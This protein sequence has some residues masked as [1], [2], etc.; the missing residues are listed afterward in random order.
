MKRTAGKVKIHPPSF[1][2]CPGIVIVILT[3]RVKIT[4]MYKRTLAIKIEKGLLQN[5]G[6]AILGPRQVGK[7]TLALEIA[8]D[9]PSIYLDLEKQEDFAK[10][11]DPVAFLSS[12]FDKLVILDE[13]Q[14]YPDLFMSLRGL[15]DTARRAGKGK[16]RYIMLGSAS[17]DLLRQTSES[18][19][20]RIAY[21]ELNGLSPMEV[22]AIRPDALRTLWLRGGFPDSYEAE[23]DAQSDIWRKNFI[24]TYV[25]RDIPLLGPRIP[26]ATLMRF[27]TMLAHVQG[28]L[29]N[30]AKLS[31]SLDVKSV[32]VARYLDMMSDLLLVRK[33]QPWYGNVKK[34]LVKSPRVYIRDS[35]ILHALLQIP[36]HEQLLS[37]PVLGKSWEG[38]VIENIIGC[39]PDHIHPFFYR[40]SAGA[41]ID[42]L[43]EI[44]FN[45]YW[46]IE[47]KHSSAPTVNNGFHIACDDLKVM[48]KYVVYT[49]NDEYPL[50]HDIM[51][52]SL[53]LLM[54]K[55]QNTLT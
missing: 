35:G 18:L 38:F 30:A 49:G 37:H 33:L 6:V 28:E 48:R 34:R 47:V 24:R 14:R 27:W 29:W 31:G 16:G 23:D 36:S 21:L 43:L 8:Q 4:R 1:F 11:K 52:I 5:A 26:A 2:S 54:A 55:I 45:E 7:T 25:E 40:T 13:V 9:K 42:L 19:A 46:A 3:R 12:H 41:E 32:T 50:G 53:P 20:G 44:K 17:H 15:I 39:L 51:A 10:L 22:Q